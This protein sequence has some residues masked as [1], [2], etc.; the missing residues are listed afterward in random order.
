[1]NSQVETLCHNLEFVNYNCE[2][3]IM[4]FNPVEMYHLRHSEAL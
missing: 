1:M 2:L 4:H 3:D